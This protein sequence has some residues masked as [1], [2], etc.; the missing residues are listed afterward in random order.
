MHNYGIFANIC[1]FSVHYSTTYTLFSFFTLMVHKV[2]NFGSKKIV[3]IMVFLEND[4]HP[5]AVITNSTF[6]LILSLLCSL[7]VYVFR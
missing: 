1:F 4:P 5:I 7:L 6:P 3:L 2:C